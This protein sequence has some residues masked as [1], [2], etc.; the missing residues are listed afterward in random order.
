[1]TQKILSRLSYGNV[2]ATLALFFALGGGY[3][4]AVTGSGTLQKGALRGI[5]FPETS[6]GEVKKLTGIG[7]LKA[8]CD[9]PGGVPRG[10]VGLDLK[11]NSGEALTLLWTMVDHGEAH[12]FPAEVSSGNEYVG[13]GE[14][15]DSIYPF[16]T[17][18]SH[19]TLNIFPADATKA[20]QATL[21]VEV[22]PPGPGGTCA[23]TASVIV[24]ALNTQ[25]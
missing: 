19:Y 15:T 16:T 4:V 11:N 14:T 1:V 7:T 2:V 25:Q 9:E 5:P 6:P 18:P 8:W 23:T 17:G 24:L 21:W 22:T 13:V 20:P 3:A 12:K 10:T